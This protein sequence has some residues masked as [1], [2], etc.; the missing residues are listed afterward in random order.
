MSMEKTKDRNR[1]KVA[2][3]KYNFHAPRH[4]AASMFIESGITPMRVQVVTRHSSI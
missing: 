1:I 4:A 2:K 3:G